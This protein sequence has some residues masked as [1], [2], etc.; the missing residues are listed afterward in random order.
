MECYLVVYVELRHE[1]MMFFWSPSSLP[2]RHHR[3]HH[4]RYCAEPGDV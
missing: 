4:H 1:G 2:S 3:H